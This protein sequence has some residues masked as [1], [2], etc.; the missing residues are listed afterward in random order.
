MGGASLHKHT[1]AMDGGG[2]GVVGGV[3]LAVEV[4]GKDVGAVRL[5]EAESVVA[6]AAAVRDDGNCWGVDDSALVSC[7]SG[8]GSVVIGVAASVD[9]GRPKGVSGVCE[10]E[11]V[12][13]ARFGGRDAHQRW[14]R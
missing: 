7:S 12:R 9:P 1:M 14:Q 13:L 10:V 11:G 8:E 4:G 5:D 6:A 3:A 2:S